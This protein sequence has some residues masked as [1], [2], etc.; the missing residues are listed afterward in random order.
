M[1][2]F[3]SVGNPIGVIIEHYSVCDRSTLDIQIAYLN[4]TAMLKSCRG[5]PKKYKI[6]EKT[7]K[8][9][10]PSNMYG[11]ACFVR[12]VCARIIWVRVRMRGAKSNSTNALT[13][14]S[15]SSKS[16]S[17]QQYLNGHHQREEQ[18]VDRDARDEVRI[19]AGLQK[20]CSRLIVLQLHQPQKTS[21]HCLKHLFLKTDRAM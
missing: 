16:K 8:T 18:T 13:S 7:N 3:S 12:S 21:I 5:K 9:K 14:S 20:I 1:L 4:N 11:T 6:N 10:H 2:F 19:W 15:F 17:K